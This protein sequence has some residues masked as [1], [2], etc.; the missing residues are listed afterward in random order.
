MRQRR[1]ALSSLQKRTI[2]LLARLGLLQFVRSHSR[3]VGSCAHL[4]RFS[5]PPHHWSQGTEVSSCSCWRRWLCVC[6]VEGEM[7]VPFYLREYSLRCDTFFLCMCLAPSTSIHPLS[8][9]FSQLLSLYIFPRARVS[10]RSRAQQMV[11]RRNDNA[12]QS[13]CDA[14][15]GVRDNS[16]RSKCTHRRQ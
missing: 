1:S 3:S 7:P 16:S 6:V 8:S 15:T 5:P 11:Q 14:S 2:D 4:L 13:P 10:A 12:D 9:S